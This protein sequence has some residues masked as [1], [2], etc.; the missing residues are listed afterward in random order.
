MASNFVHFRLHNL[1]LIH[2]APKIAPQKLQ[3][4]AGKEMENG[5]AY[6]SKEKLWTRHR[7]FMIPK[8]SPLEVSYDSLLCKVYIHKPINFRETSNGQHVH[9]LKWE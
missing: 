6:A 5:Q 7:G 3:V 9:G 8:A 1:T 4:L 2:I